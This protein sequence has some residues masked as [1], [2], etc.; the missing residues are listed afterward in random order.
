MGNVIN[1]RTIAFAALF[2]ASSLVSAAPAINFA[3]ASFTPGAGWPGFNA[4]QVDNT[5][6]A[7]IAISGF[8][9]TT[10]TTYRQDQGYLWLRNNAGDHGL[11]YCSEGSNCG[12]TDTTG[13]GD[14]NEIS[15]LNKQEILRLTLPTGKVWTDVQVSSLDDGGTNGDETGTFYWSN[16]ATPNLQDNST[17]LI[18]F[19]H[20]GLGWNGSTVEGSIFSYLVAHGFDVHAKYLFFRSG[21]YDG[22]GLSTNGTNNDYLVWGVNVAA[23]IPEPETY[24]MLLAGLGLLGFAARRRK[25]KLAA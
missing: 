2:L 1:K 14:Y 10:P 7:G 9:Y 11:G 22:S 12:P 17:S 20:D 21:E 6:F 15:N 5:S 19:S 18:N 3:S 8:T 25:L 16:S 4:A 24:A 13:G 23:P